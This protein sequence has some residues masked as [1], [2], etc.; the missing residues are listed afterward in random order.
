MWVMPM[1]VWV[2]RRV[3]RRVGHRVEREED[4]TEP[5]EGL[6]GTVRR[7]CVDVR[8]DVCMVSIVGVVVD[9][10]PLI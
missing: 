5:G 8:C 3:G 4:D 2:R 6:C 1:L 10:T 7:R 9:N